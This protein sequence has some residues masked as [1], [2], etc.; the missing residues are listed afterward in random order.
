MFGW[1]NSNEKWE[2]EDR[3]LKIYCIFCGSE[4]FGG[5]RNGSLE[6]TPSN[7]FPEEG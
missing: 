4:S 2:F 1:G 3:S 6:R 7:H 5:K